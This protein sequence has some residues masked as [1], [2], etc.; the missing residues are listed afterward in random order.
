MIEVDNMVKHYGEVRAVD[1]VSF[2]VQ[3]G[4]TF[5]LLKPN[6]AG[7]TTTM[8]ILCCLRRFDSGKATVCGSDLVK[9]TH[10]VRASMRSC[11]QETLL[12]DSP[13][14]HENLAFSASPYSKK[15][16]ER[17]EFSSKVLGVG[18]S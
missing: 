7:K 15:F 9:E 5:G 16:R 10:N 14:V 6:G 12:C 8:E 18:N 4:E 3:E 2:S 1:G 17:L 13:N 11:P